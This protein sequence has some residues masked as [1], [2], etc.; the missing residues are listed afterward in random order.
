MSVG[1][2]TGDKDR[3]I[4]YFR[5]IAR[6]KLAGTC[7]AYKVC[8]GA[9]D[10]LCQ[11][12]KYG[13]PVG[14]GGAGQGRTFHENFRALS[15][16]RLKMCVIK[17][18]HEPEMKSSFIG[19][20]ITMPVMAS[21][22]S[23]VRISMNNAMGEEEFQRGLIEGARLSGTI[24]L[25]GNTVDAPDHPGVDIIASN[26]GW[27]IP[28]FKPQSQER[29]LELFKRAEHANPIAI[30]VDLDGC[31]STNWAIRG[32]PLFRKSEKEL[33]ELV[34]STEKPVLFKGIMTVE[35]AS[36]VVDSGAKALGV[37]NHGGRILDY[38][39]GVADV[40]P[41]IANEFKNKIVIMAD[42]CVRTGYDAIK[43]LALGAD[44]SLIGR[45]LARMSI[46]GGSEAVK[47]YLDYVKNDLRLAMLMTGCDNLKEISNKILVKDDNPVECIEE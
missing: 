39:Q 2:A 42:G 16:Y 27:G 14:F 46:A 7:A 35:D 45:E 12:M 38:G 23:G 21:S 44:V 25:S 8:D 11:G 31:G 28:V 37:S 24:G 1:D 17:E 15:R 29:L 22:V 40:L 26:G 43:L 36:K 20:E 41:I 47:L 32:K 3:D 10:R 30:G 33:R 18:H 9:P 5:D 4:S 34:D 13:R 19:K 6:K